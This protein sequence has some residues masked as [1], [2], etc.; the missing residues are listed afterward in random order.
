MFGILSM[1]PCKNT[2]KLPGASV[3]PSPSVLKITC[4]YLDLECLEVG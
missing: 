2:V 1:T 3:T 4:I